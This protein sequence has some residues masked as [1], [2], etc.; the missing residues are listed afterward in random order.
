MA[1][2]AAVGAPL[3]LSRNVQG[4]LTKDMQDLAGTGAE[5]ARGLGSMR[6]NQ[7]AKTAVEANPNLVPSIARATEIEKT[8]GASLPALARANGD[9][10]ISNYLQSQVSRVENT[11]FTAEMKRQYEVAEEALKKAKKGIAPSMEEV[12]TYV[13]N[14]AVA[15]Q[16]SALGQQQALIKSLNE[17][18]DK[19]NNVGATAFYNVRSGEDIGSET[20]NLINAQ[21]K[22]ALEKFKPEYTKILTDAEN[23][24]VTLG[25]DQA[26]EL[27]DLVLEKKADEIYQ[28]FPKLYSMI[29]ST[30]KPK[31]AQVSK[32]MQ[33]KYTFAKAEGVTKPVSIKDLDS[34]KRR[35]NEDLRNVDR[36]RPEYRFLSELRTKLD[37]AIDTMPD[38]FKNAYR[39]VDERYYQEIG[40][41]YRNA[42]G[43]LK[44]DR[45][46]F[47]QQVTPVLTKNPESLREA[48]TAMGKTPDAYRI[49]EDAFMLDL[50]KNRALFKLDGSINPT[51]LQRYIR[52]NKASIDQIPGFQTKLE[53][54]ATDSNALIADRDRILS[55]QE[56]VKS[57]LAESLW[58]RAYG[59]T[60]GLAGL[61]RNG[62]NNP[63]EMDRLLAATNRSSDA[64]DAVKSAVV[65]DLT[66]IPGDR[67]EVFR[68]Q[69]AVLERLFGAQGAK[70]LLDVVEASQR[71][72]DNPLRF[73]INVQQAGKTATERMLGSKIEQTA[74]EIRN[75]VMG[76]FRVMANHISRFFSN[77]ASKTEAQ[78]VQRFL[79][80]LEQLPEFA[81]AVKEIDQRGFTE[82]A[83]RQIS[84]VLGNYSVALAGGGAAGVVG[85][86]TVEDTEAEGY[87][88]TDPALLE[89]FV[90]NPRR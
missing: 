55:I 52:E 64:L 72:R 59:T 8:L 15:E 31:E 12:D 34:L 83:L 44:I 11:A 7:L 21:R 36:T 78:E 90:G 19:I 46:K 38:T 42:Q 87:T 35:L 81:T 40:I 76:Q 26:K 22:V 17:I 71:I 70:N 47:E 84:R 50:S 85:G 43:V 6:A 69:Q 54:L 53:K 77:T 58:S 61:V 74:S 88:P 23:A 10:S 80:N 5:A 56:Q 86:R 75:P 27:R 60:G 33:E 29:Q 3:A 4:F 39:N 24:G 51:V 79:R 28:N 66:T 41:P 18:N 45:A 30:L 1:A 2:G 37:E 32:K 20:R 62:L 89:G 16:A 68:Q 73:S 82:K 63:Q 48:I 65:K 9:T 57:Q 25:A 13:K 67:L 14:K 49:A